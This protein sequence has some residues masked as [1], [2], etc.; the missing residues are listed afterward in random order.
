MAEKLSAAE[1]L[2]YF[3][4]RPRGSQLGAWCSRQSA[5]ISSRSLLEAK[6]EEVKRKFAEGKVPLPSFWGGYRVVPDR[7]EFWQGQANRLHDRF[8]YS[9]QEGRRW[10]IERLAP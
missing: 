10:Y 5:V 9:Y 3:A 2:R 4:T 8:L 6:L 7:I 1:S